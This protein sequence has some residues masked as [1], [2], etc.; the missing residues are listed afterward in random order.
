M[1]LCSNIDN[2]LLH[3]YVSLNSILSAA[4]LYGHCFGSCKECVLTDL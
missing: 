1:G 2:Y 3:L 4:L